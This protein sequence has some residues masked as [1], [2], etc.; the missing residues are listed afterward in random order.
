MNFII[1]QLR[2]TLTQFC[3]FSDQCYD[4]QSQKCQEIDGQIYIGREKQG[5]CIFD[6]KPNN[7]VDFCYNLRGT[8]KKGKSLE[9]SQQYYLC[10]ESHK[11]FGVGLCNG[12]Q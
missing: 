4:I 10:D 11:L 6:S 2:F 8:I 5:L 7:Q 9:N 3:N 1:S 12:R